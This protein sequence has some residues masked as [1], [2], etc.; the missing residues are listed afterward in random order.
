MNIPH[1]V[2]EKHRLVHRF[3]RVRAVVRV[4]IYAALA[5][6]ATSCISA[7]LAAPQS[8][9]TIAPTRSLSLQEAVKLDAL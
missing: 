6:I 9:S 3:L 7:P 1:D 5:I 8:D 4:T 2:I